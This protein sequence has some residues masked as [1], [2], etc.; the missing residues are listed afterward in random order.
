MD[1]HIQ[2]HRRSQNITHMEVISQLISFC[3][4]FFT[5]LLSV[6]CIFIEASAAECQLLWSQSSA[7]NKTAA[8]SLLQYFS[9]TQDFKLIFDPIHRLRQDGLRVWG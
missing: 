5:N 2:K 8:A 9:L 7:N 1:R 4:C 6:T 3:E